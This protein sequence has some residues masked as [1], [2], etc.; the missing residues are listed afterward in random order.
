MAQG[1]RAIFAEV[2]PTY[3]RVNRVLTQELDAAPIH[4]ALRRA[5]S[6]ATC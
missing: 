5:R 6:R 2:P 3:E 4:V 1:L